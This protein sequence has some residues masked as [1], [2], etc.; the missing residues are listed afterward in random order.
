MDAGEDDETRRGGQQDSPVRRVI[1]GSEAET[2]VDSWAPSA[3][4]TAAVQYK[5]GVFSSS[6]FQNLAL[7]KKKI[8]HHIKLVV[9]V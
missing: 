3:D 4:A 5:L 2:G 8:P 1:P 6:K 9:H 7:C